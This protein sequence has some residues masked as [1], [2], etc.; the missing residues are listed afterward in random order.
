MPFDAMVAQSPSDADLLCRA[1]SYIDT[2]NR[3][4]KGAYMIKSQRRYCATAA[5]AKACNVRRFWRS[6][7]QLRHLTRLLVKE[8]PREGVFSRWCLTSRARLVHFNDQ[9][10][11]SHQDMM[12]LFNRAIT[13]QTVLTIVQ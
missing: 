1:R 10:T 8:L 5:L 9:A 13:H 6:N 7:N 11:T 12:A 2:P 4:L 3:W